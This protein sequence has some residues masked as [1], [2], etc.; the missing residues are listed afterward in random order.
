MIR[1]TRTHFFGMELPLSSP[2]VVER[3]RQIEPSSNTELNYTICRSY[4]NNFLSRLGD[5]PKANFWSTQNGVQILPSTL[6]DTDATSEDATKR[7]LDVNTQDT[8]HAVTLEEAEMQNNWLAILKKYEPPSSSYVEMN[9][10]ENDFLT[11]ESYTLQHQIDDLSWRDDF[12]PDAVLRLSD[13]FDCEP[14]HITS[15]II[16]TPLR[17]YPAIGGIDPKTLTTFTC[18][19]KLPK[20]LQM[21]I[22]EFVVFAPRTVAVRC[23]EFHPN[24]R[25]GRHGGPP[26]PPFRNKIEELVRIIQTKTNSAAPI[27]QVNQ[28]LRNAA[29]KFYDLCFGT[30][31]YKHRRTTLRGVNFNFNIKKQ[32][33]DYLVRDAKVHINLISDTLYVEDCE[34]ENV[35]ESTFLP[36]SGQEVGKVLRLDSIR[37]IAFDMHTLKEGRVMICYA[38]V[39]INN[40][41]IEE[42]IFVARLI[43]PRADLKPDEFGYH[44]ITSLA[45]G[46]L[47]LVDLKKQE[48]LFYYDK[49]VS[50]F[51]DFVWQYR[52]F[53]GRPGLNGILLTDGP[54]IRIVGLLSN[55]KR[56]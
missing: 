34:A 20:E 28:E 43:H 40:P 30:M 31:I 8:S 53:E 36:P 6:P 26:Q 17:N 56:I 23:M 49:F 11:A 37:S 42:I 52:F 24:E 2:C 48:A 38:S 3:I 27:L 25:K 29:L 13:H 32:A 54:R 19:S 9:V 16:P 35:L 18:F 21:R 14:A 12:Y 55:G 50:N 45:R 39:L 10:L 22:L 15:C 33:S 7:R 5:A 1:P 47:E 41:N 4:R 44:R 51:Y 46:K